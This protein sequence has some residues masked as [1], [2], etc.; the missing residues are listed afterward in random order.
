MSFHSIGSTIHG[1]TSKRDVL[2][3]LHKKVGQTGKNFVSTKE[4]QITLIIF[5]IVTFKN[6]N[7]GQE[8]RK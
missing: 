5:L 7:T 2:E 1:L 8:V 3:T 4:I 6:S